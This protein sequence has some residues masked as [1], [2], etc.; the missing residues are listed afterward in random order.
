[1][2][3]I[4]KNADASNILDALS[5][6]QAVI[7]FDLNGNILTANEN[8]CEALGYSLSEIK[9]RH[10]R[11][12]CD[13]EYANSSEYSRFWEE[14][15]SGKFMSIEFKRVKKDGSTIWIEATYN[16]IFKGLKPYKV[17]KFA[18]DITAK[19]LKSVEDR[20]ILEAISRSQAVIEFTPQ[21]DI[22]R[23]LRLP[24]I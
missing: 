19:K 22:L 16:P 8:F 24:I 15:N 14:L 1:M 18:T 21:G 17:V 2:L 20:N 5:K 9:G 11:I 23:R 3:G 10:H 12:F 13:S 4:G 7:E 6:S